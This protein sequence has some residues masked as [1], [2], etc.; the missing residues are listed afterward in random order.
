[1][2]TEFTGTFG[3]VISA[4]YQ[5]PPLRRAFVFRPCESFLIDK[6]YLEEFSV[7]QGL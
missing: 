5:A 4:S 3:F 1:M 6:L 7:F 2:I